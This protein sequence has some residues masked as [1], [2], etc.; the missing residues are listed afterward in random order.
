MLL[1]SAVLFGH[2]T[3]NNCTLDQYHSQVCVC[4]CVHV[5]SRVCV[6]RT[7]LLDLL[8]CS[9]PSH[10]FY[11][12]FPSFSLTSIS[13]WQPGA[14]S[15]RPPLCWLDFSLVNSQRLSV[16]SSGSL[17]TD[18]THSLFP[19]SSSSNPWR[20][21][22]TALMWCILSDLKSKTLSERLTGHC[23]FKNT[24]NILLVYFVFI[25]NIVL[26]VWTDGYKGFRH[27]M[28]WTKNVYPV[29]SCKL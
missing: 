7:H 18:Y 23:V 25:V 8:L 20:R 11:P 22:G 12:S 21:D 1:L 3:V 10:L 27:V 4:V 6:W 24:A 28:Q 19:T 2:L 5:S 17:L 15:N 14:P 13:P 26:A 29:Y 9:S 16:T